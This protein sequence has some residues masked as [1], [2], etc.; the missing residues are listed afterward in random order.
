MPEHRVHF[1][2][3][4]TGIGS[5]PFLDI[6][7][8][9]RDIFRLFPDVPFWPQF[10][11]RSL[12]ED[13]II[14]FS[15]GLPLLDIDQERRRLVVDQASNKERQLVSF[16]D[17]FLADDVDHFAISRE[18][19]PGL[20][21][22]LKLLEDDPENKNRFVKG[23]CVGPVTFASGIPGPDGKPVIHNSELLEAYTQG[24]AIKALWQAR[25]L[26]ATGRTP[27]LFLDEPSLSGFGSAFSPLEREEVIRLLRMVID[28][29]KQQHADLLIGIH[30]CGNTD[31]GMILEAGPDIVN[32]DAFAY[33]DYFLLYPKEITAFVNNGGFIAWGIVPTA[34]FTGEETVESLLLILNRGFQTLESWGLSA[35]TVAACSILTP[36]CGMGT[37]SPETAESALSLLSLLSAGRAD[38]PAL[39]RGAPAF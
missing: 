25:K 28:Y 29:L 6:Q 21:T 35:E 27:I 23:Q 18:F 10:V 26:S 19:A 11:R 14:Q 9:C 38:S 8:T 37:M 16:Y 17:H 24:L 39:S 31:W 1:H 32:F 13:M 5:V 12:Q 15:E 7:R 3:R 34:D 36:S 2:L 30:C 4:A 20:Y 33:L 22:L